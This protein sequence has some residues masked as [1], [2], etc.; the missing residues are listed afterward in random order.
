MNIKLIEG[1]SKD[2]GGYSVDGVEFLGEEFE[3]LVDE[4]KEYAINTGRTVLT[5]LANLLRAA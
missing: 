1:T 4:A 3:N 5:C 2:F